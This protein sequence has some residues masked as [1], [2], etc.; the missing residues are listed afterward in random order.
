MHK[1]IKNIENSTYFS[2]YRTTVSWNT[3]FFF[4]KRKTIY[5][6][7]QSRNSNVICEPQC[8]RMVILLSHR[9]KLRG[10]LTQTH[11]HAHKWWSFCRKLQNN[12]QASRHNLHFSDL[13]HITLQS[14][15]PGSHN[16][17]RCS[18]VVVLYICSQNVLF[19]HHNT[20]AGKVETMNVTMSLGKSIL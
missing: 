15:P 16:Y 18:A 2:W 10:C 11:S 4:Y 19:C 8:A 20:C 3:V 14:P 1:H 7:W 6:K 13:P 17:R 5:Y 12:S 9:S